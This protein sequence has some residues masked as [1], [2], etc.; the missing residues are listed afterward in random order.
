MVDDLVALHLIG[1]EMADA[2]LYDGLVFLIG[3]VLAPLS[4]EFR[5]SIPHDR[6]HVVSIAF[7]I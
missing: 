2:A 6:K 5:Q 1:P 4:Y 7:E 3:A